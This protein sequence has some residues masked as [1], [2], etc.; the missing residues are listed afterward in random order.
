MS[1][2][3]SWVTSLPT[4]RRLVKPV[5]WQGGKFKIQI[6]IFISTKENICFILVSNL[7]RRIQIRKI[8]AVS[9]ESEKKP[10]KAREEKKEE[11]EGNNVKSGKYFLHFVVIVMLLYFTRIAFEMM[12]T[13][14]ILLL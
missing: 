11:N 2:T 10:T 12:N 3:S 8:A 5:R 1:T 13:K 6:K 14:L 7:K 9:Q 4:C